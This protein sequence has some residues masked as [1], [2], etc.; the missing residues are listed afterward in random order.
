MAQVIPVVVQQSAETRRVAGQQ[1]IEDLNVVVPKGDNNT[2]YAS[3]NQRWL[4]FLDWPY[5][6]SILRENL[7]KAGFVYTG[8]M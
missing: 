5:N 8:T 3:E 2:I 1:P 4:S 6:N 7:A